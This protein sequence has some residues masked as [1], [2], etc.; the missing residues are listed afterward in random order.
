MIDPEERYCD[1]C[2]KKFLPKTRRNIFCSDICCERGVKKNKRLKMKKKKEPRPCRG[3]G[4]VFEPRVGNQFYCASD[5]CKQRSRKISYTKSA[6]K[7]SERNKTKEY[8][9]RW[10]SRNPDA[11]LYRAAKNRA[12][13]R[14]IEFDIDQSDVFVPDVCPV[15]G[16][17]ISIGGDRMNSPSLDRIDNNKGYIKGNVCVISF[18][19][20]ALKSD[21]SLDEIRAIAN[22]LESHRK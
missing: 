19:A 14:G 2:G 16:I 10:R 22:Y 18:R 5:P 4:I 3:C 8:M 11:V 20:N 12:K 17:K 13:T 21:G 9:A 6:E 15:L 1:N 7:Y